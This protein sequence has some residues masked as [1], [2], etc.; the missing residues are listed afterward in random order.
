MFSRRDA[1]TTTNDRPSTP[2]QG[3]PHPPT[4]APAAPQPVAQ[5]ATP[6]PVP[7][8]PAPAAAHNADESLVA[9]EDTFEGQLNTTRGVRILGT[10]RGTIESAQYVHIEEHAQVESD[11]TAAEVVIAGTYTGTLIGRQRVEIRST[12][13]VS[14]KIETEK[15]QLHEGG[16]FDGQLH[17]QKPSG[18]PAG[19]APS[20]A[21][22]A[23]AMGDGKDSGLTRRT[24]HVDLP[25]DTPLARDA[26]SP[27]S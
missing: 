17:M 2:P 14:G 18:T 21:S 4:P 27:K 3:D 25:S 20:I 24:R 16:F 22:A 13:H 19:S 11:I 8:Q 26:D 7:P 10:V 15:L 6:R 9:R 1:S 5:Q 23:P 12:G